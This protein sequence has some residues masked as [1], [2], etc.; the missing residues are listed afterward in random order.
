MVNYKLARRYAKGL[1]KFAVETKQEELISS[2]IQK[3]STLLQNSP[4]LASFLASPII[5][6]AKKSEVCA[7]VFKGFSAPVSKFVQVV[8]DHGRE[9]ELKPILKQYGIIA[10][11]EQGI[12]KVVIT[13]VVELPKEQQDQIIS[14]N[15]SFFN[16]KTSQYEIINR[17]DPSLIGGFILRIGDLQLDA[18]IKSKLNKLKKDFNVNHYTPKF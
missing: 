1:L 12:N 15:A 13:S 8:L 10:K 5:D 18:S 14:S 4:D 3:L 16:L 6:K 11:E 2:D 17:I 7:E 9:S